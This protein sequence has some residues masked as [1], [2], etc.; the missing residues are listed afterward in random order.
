MARRETASGSHW[1]P[2]SDMMM[3]LMMVFMLLAA[4]YMIR[5]DQTTTLVVREYEVTRSD[6]RRAL[7]DSFAENFKEWDAELLG[8]MTIRFRNPD[9]LFAT[10]SAKLNPKFTAILDEFIPR[11]VAILSREPFYSATKEV[12]IE[13]HT[14]AFWD[15]AKDPLD[16][17]MKNMALSQARTRSTLQY[18]L[19]LD[20]IGP[21]RDWLIAR[22]TAN[23]LSSSRPIKTS[24]TE[25]SQV[26]NDAASQR[27]EFRIVTNAEDR[28]AKIAEAIKK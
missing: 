21:Q 23:G 2:L 25:G 20:A 27:V 7:Q 13:G 14:S 10:G 5:V 6:L 17:Y 18:I 22:L 12:R 11:Y 28:M 4:V 8:D 26:N 3:G 24:A 15:N 1:I 16:A 19:G 9:V